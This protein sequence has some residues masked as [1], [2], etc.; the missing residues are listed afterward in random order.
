[1]SQARR[2]APYLIHDIF[3]TIKSPVFSEIILIFQR[4]DLYRPYYI[5][6][7]MF[8]QMH[9]ERKFRLVFC[10]EVSKRYRHLGLQVMKRRMEYEVEERRLDFLESPPTLTV[11]EVNSWTG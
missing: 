6:F 1:M 8:R 5:P 11:S 4:P 3:S 2:D 7:D 9:S 10:M